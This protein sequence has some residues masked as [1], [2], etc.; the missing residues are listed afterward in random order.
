M[1]WHKTRDTAGFLLSALI[2]ASLAFCGAGVAWSGEEG[3]GEWYHA[4][5][6]VPVVHITPEQA[7]EEAWREALKVAAEQASLE[8]V[9]AAAMRVHEADGRLKHEHFA[10]F[11]HTGT[12]ARVVAIDTLFDGVEMR[13]VGDNGRNEPV[14]RVEIR[15]R[16][17][18]ET[19]TP[20][21][22]FALELN[23]ADKDSSNVYR[24]GE[25]LVMELE[26]TRECHVTVFNL[27][28]NDSLLVVF[29]NELMPDNRLAAG[30]LLRIPPPGA[31]WELPVGL[32]PGRDTDQEM[33]LAVATKQP[34]PFRR[35][36]GARQGLLAV[37]EAMLAINRWLAAIP[38]DQRIEAMTAYTIVR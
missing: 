31:G 18:P 27:Y 1:I 36:A 24:H 34:V 10:R 29:P 4:Q 16:V 21:P 37:E 11:V 20:D 19:G 23:L 5:E 30:E 13:T 22:G 17:R 2:A 32:L 25:P 33:L 28:G 26:A 15:A 12:R 3:S 8:V 6:V 38:A 35:A 7:R 9:A 14:H